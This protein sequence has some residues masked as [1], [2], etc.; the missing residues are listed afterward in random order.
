MTR[1]V[2]SQEDNQHEEGEEG[3]AGLKEEGKSE[4]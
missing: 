2:L 3:A 4:G 1:K